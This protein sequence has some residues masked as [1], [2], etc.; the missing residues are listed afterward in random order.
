MKCSILACPPATADTFPGYTC[1]IFE[2][3][4]LYGLKWYLESL[5]PYG[6]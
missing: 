5:R 1:L 3:N 4:D 6:F 2:H